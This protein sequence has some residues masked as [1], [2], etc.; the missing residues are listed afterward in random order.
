MASLHI[1][2][3]TL[4][5]VLTALGVKNVQAGDEQVEIQLG[6][7]ALRLSEINAGARATFRGVRMRLR[8][9]RLQDGLRVEFE[10][11]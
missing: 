8:D 6:D 10:A 3:T 11:E 5:A 4:Q 9:V 7:D 1:D 2:P